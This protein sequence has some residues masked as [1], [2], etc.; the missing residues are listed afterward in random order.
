MSAECYEC[1]DSGE[2]MNE[3]VCSLCWKRVQLRLKQAERKIA[4]LEHQLALAQGK[5]FLVGE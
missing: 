1:C 2:V 4:S 5:F 3:A